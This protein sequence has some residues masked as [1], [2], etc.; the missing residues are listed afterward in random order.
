MIPHGRVHRQQL[1]L[2][3]QLVL[4]GEY[5]RYKWRKEKRGKIVKMRQA[6][7]SARKVLG[8][9]QLKAAVVLCLLLGSGGLKELTFSFG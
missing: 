2:N 1:L 9:F 6:V 3:Q 8:A 7:N 5:A 4:C